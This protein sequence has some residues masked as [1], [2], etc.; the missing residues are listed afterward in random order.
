MIQQWKSILVWDQQFFRRCVSEAAYA[1][2]LQTA[3]KYLLY[4][5]ARH[6]FQDQISIIKI[7]LNNII[8]GYKKKNRQSYVYIWSLEGNQHADVTQDLNEFDTP[9]PDYSHPIHAFLILSS[10]A[11]V[12]QT[13]ALFHFLFTVAVSTDFQMINDMFLQLQLA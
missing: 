9:G 3:L 10:F 2:C 11:F 12:G 7:R 8:I 6:V 1:E 13:L 4:S 5:C